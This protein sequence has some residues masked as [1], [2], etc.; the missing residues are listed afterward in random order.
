MVTF[1]YFVIYKNN[2]KGLNPTN[3]NSPFFIQSKNVLSD[4]NVILLP[5][6][7]QNVN[8]ISEKSKMAKCN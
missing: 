4:S 1:V 8:I 7:Q 3:G 6:A 5:F 2:H